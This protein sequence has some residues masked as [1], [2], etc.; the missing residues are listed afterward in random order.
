MQD[1]DRFE[2]TNAP[3]EG[4][5]NEEILIDVTE[6]GE[7]WLHTQDDGIDLLLF[8]DEARALAQALIDAAAE[9]EEGATPDD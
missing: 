6:D 2:G 3:A 4:D 9:A 8:P 1:S 5:E 7:V